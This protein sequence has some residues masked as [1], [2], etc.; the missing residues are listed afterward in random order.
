MTDAG[1]QSGRTRDELLA[2]LAYIQS[3]W[4]ERRGWLFGAAVMRRIWDLL[5]DT[6]FRELV[7]AAEGWTTQRVAVAE[8]RRRIELLPSFPPPIQIESV[9]P[10]DWTRGITVR[11][12]GGA[13][14]RRP[15]AG[16]LNFHELP[17]WVQQTHHAVYHFAR[18]Q[19]LALCVTLASVRA[20]FAAELVP[21][22]GMLTDWQHELR[23]AE[24]GL[25]RDQADA[26]HRGMSDG[27]KLKKAR[28]R[29]TEAKERCTHLASDYQAIREREADVART[30]EFAA[31]ADLLR[32]IAGNPF[33][34]VAFDPHWRTETV[35]NIAHGIVAGRAFDRLPILADALEEAGCDNADV[36]S[37]CRSSG[38]HAMGCWVLTGL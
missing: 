27:P 18:G 3:L 11:S 12:V 24:V 19:V 9:A 38:P 33:H 4:N 10:P 17:Q 35:A 29:L 15:A 7:E 26:H 28:Q 32:C 31:Q 37:H 13:S 20:D 1:W 36:L 34:P 23:R 14:A 6:R 16:I 21:E 8:L 22:Q 30:G 2:M 25:Q 5:T